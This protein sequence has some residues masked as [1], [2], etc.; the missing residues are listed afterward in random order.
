M[1]HYFLLQAAH[2][3]AD[4]ELVELLCAALARLLFPDGDSVD[5]NI[6]GVR[7]C[8]EAQTLSSALFV[9]CHVN[10]LQVQWKNFL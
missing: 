5:S 6:Q 8:C 3:F 1:H 9:I 4:D 7:C 10:L 2:F